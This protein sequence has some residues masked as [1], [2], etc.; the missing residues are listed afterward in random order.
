MSRIECREALSRIE[1]FLD[2]E[3]VGEA[4]LE[5]HEHV[6]GCPP[7]GERVEFQRRLK[8]LLRSAC[9]ECDIPPELAA[10]LQAFL[11]AADD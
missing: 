10:R 2:G 4:S 9:R 1:L 7:C 5:V 11:D 6:E 3:L 8:D